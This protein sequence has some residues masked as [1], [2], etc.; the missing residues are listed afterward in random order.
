MILTKI[1]NIYNRSNYDELK[2]ITEQNNKFKKE[3]L[4]RIKGENKLKF[5]QSKNKLDK[6]LMSSEH[7][8]LFASISL[9]L[10][11]KLEILEIGTFD[12]FNSYLLSQLFP[13]ANILTIDL[14]KNDEAFKNT[15]KRSEKKTFLNHL[16]TRKNFIK[17][18]PNVKFIELNSIYL[19]FFKKKFD[20]VW[21]DG[22]HGYPFATIDIINSLRMLNTSGIILCDDVFVKKIHK[23]DKFY[24]SNST[25]ETLNELEKCN[26]IK[27]SLFYKRLNKLN[28]FDPNKR[29][30]IALVK[31]TR[32]F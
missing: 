17:K 7:Q 22:A 12:G 23:T 4:D 19:T 25:I 20:I 29:K 18:S 15:Y 16:K 27:F 3:G 32:K 6:N 21:I 30:F 9:K 26:C 10:K 28:N 8:V 31:K 24:Y 5:I 14:P 11:K 13:K 2:I 1:K